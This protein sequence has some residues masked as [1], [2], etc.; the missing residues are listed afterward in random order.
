VR[1]HRRVGLIHGK[2]ARL[3]RAREL[4][5]WNRDEIDI[6]V[7]TSAFGL[8]VDKP[9]IRAVIHATCPEDV[10]RFYQDVGRGGRDGFA[11]VSVLIWTDEDARK[12]RRLA[13]PTFIGVERGIE[14]WTAMFHSAHR[15]SDDDPIWEVGLD[16]SPSFRPGDIDMHNDENE[17]W[18][19][20][21]LHL[22]RAGLVEILGSPV[23]TEEGCITKKALIRVLDHEHLD[24]R[25]WEAH[26]DPMRLDLLAQNRKSWE[27]L[28]AALRGREC[29]SRVFEAA[30]TSERHSVTV[31]RA[32]GGCPKCRA[33]GVASRCGR[34][35]PRH[36]PERPWPSRALADSVARFVQGEPTAVIFTRVDEETGPNEDLAALAAWCGRGGLSNFLLP[37]EWVDPWR[38]L[39]LSL[40]ARPLFLQNDIPLGIIRDQPCV[41]FLFGS[42]R[43]E[44][45]RLWIHRAEFPRPTLLILPE[46][47]RDPER[48]ER[49]MRDLVVRTPRMTLDQ[50]LETYCE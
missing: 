14:R 29:I 49:F 13:I 22:M 33:D 43:G 17:R 32:C 12:A 47:M 40:S 19:L 11:S 48:P 44:W 46:D 16:V 25:C 31:V 50:W 10:D 34:L 24:S 2:T 27:L 37:R 26:V 18:N 5:R 30:Y 1:G 20:R 35:I 39:L 3:D 15:C 23:S 38:P 4:E 21:T 9:D 41:G 42:L 7:A 6:M 36:T 8:G 45:P 28:K